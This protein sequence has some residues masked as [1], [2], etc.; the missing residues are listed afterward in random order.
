MVS[1]PEISRSRLCRSAESALPRIEPTALWKN[2]SVGASEILRSMAR[3]RERLVSSMS[4]VAS[5]PA[6]LRP[7]EASETGLRREKKFCHG[8]LTEAKPDKRDITEMPMTPMRSSDASLKLWALSTV[9][10]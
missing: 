7:I 5:S 6:A 3:S 4:L 2:D 9:G 1:S 10:P 8:E